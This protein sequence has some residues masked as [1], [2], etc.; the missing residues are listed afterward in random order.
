MQ[1]FIRGHYQWLRDLFS[2]RGL[3]FCYL[4]LLAEEVLNYNA[5]FLSE[6]RKHVRAYDVPDLSDYI[7]GGTPFSSVPLLAFTTGE[8]AKMPE[9]KTK[10]KYMPVHIPSDG[11]FG[12]TFISLS[13][14]IWSAI[15]TG[16]HRYRYRLD[17]NQ[18]DIAEEPQ[19][20]YEDKFPIRF[21]KVSVENQSVSSCRQG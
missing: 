21:S 14:A 4:P 5:P 12:N 20:M 17:D 1:A 3:E 19:P 8:E 6:E 11:R 13:G 10:L 16:H 7:V 2:R 18:L 9:G 15:S